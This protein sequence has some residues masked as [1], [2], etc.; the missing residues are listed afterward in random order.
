MELSCIMGW[1]S[2]FYFTI[3]KDCIPHLDINHQQRCIMGSREREESHI[4]GSAFWSRSSEVNPWTPRN[5]CSQLVHIVHKRP[6]SGKSL[7]GPFANN[8]NNLQTVTRL[9]IGK[10]I[11]RSNEIKVF[12]LCLWTYQH[13]TPGGRGVL[14]HSLIFKKKKKRCWE[15]LSRILDCSSL[16][17]L[18]CRSRGKEVFVRKVKKLANYNIKFSKSCPV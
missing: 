7:G 3:Q 14:F 4:Y 11:S 8:M 1:S 6:Q 12:L 18:Q 2:I 13:S 10:F 5:G 9:G 16:G 15:K 17:L